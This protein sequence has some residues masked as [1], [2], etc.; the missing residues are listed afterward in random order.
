M[1]RSL[2]WCLGLGAAGTAL[3]VT[4]GGAAAPFAMALVGGVVGGAAGNFGHEVCKALDRQVVGELL[5]GRSA[6]AENHVVV[7]ALRLAQ[8]RALETVLRRFDAARSSHHDQ[9]QRSEAQRFSEELARFIREERKAATT[10]AFVKPSTSA[11]ESKSCGGK[12]C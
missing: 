10:L 6:I 8:L 4:T 7:Q 3:T 1:F 5:D 11:P 12:S 2:A 9:R